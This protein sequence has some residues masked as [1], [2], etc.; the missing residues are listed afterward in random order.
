MGS[1][2]SSAEVKERAA[3]SKRIDRNLRK[4]AEERDRKSESTILHNKGFAQNEPAEKR[5]DV[6]SNIIV[7]MATIIRAL[8]KFI[9]QV[10]SIRDQESMDARRILAVAESTKSD[11]SFTRGVLMALHFSWMILIKIATPSYVPT[12]DDFLHIPV[13]AT[14]LSRC[15]TIQKCIFRWSCH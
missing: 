9:Y 3:T 4:E 12:V 5:Q 15:I 1:G 14:G 2:C 10:A 13:P 6:Y 7:G 11:H 8:D